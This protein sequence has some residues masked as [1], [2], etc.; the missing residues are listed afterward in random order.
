MSISAVFDRSQVTHE[1][2]KFDLIDRTKFDLSEVTLKESE[3]ALMEKAFLSETTSLTDGALIMPNAIYAKDSIN[4]WR[5]KTHGLPYHIKQKL[6][7]K[8]KATLNRAPTENDL[9]KYHKYANGDLR[10]AVELFH[11][12]I[13][14]KQLWL[15]DGKTIESKAKLIAN[16]T[17]AFVT[18]IQTDGYRGRKWG[19]KVS[20]Y[21]TIKKV[22]EPDLAE[23]G[24]EPLFKLTKKSK[25]KD[26]YSALIRY[27]S[28][29]YLIGKFEKQAD[30]LREYIEILFGNVRDYSTPYASRKC[31]NEFKASRIQQK[32][33]INDMVIQDIDD[34][35]NVVPLAA[36]IASSVS[37]PVIRRNELMT[38]IR[39]FENIAEESGFV[40][41]FITL[42]APSAYHANSR[43]FNGNKPNKTQKYLTN[44]WAKVRAKLAR[45]NIK[46]FGVRVTEPHA[47][48]TPH[49]HMILFFQADD[50]QAVETS[51]FKYFTQ[52]HWQELTNDKTDECDLLTIKSFYKNRKLGDVDL[53][54][55]TKA[56]DRP[57][58]RV[59]FVDIDK[60]FGS[61]TG[62]IAKY[63]A[64]NIDAAH[65]TDKETGKPLIDDETGKPINDET[66]I[67]VLAWTSRWRIRQ[68]QFL[69]G[70]PVTTYREC[71]K[72]MNDYSIEDSV[73]KDLTGSTDEFDE[74]NFI[75]NFQEVLNA[76]DTGNFAKYVQLTGGA[77][78][79][80]NG[81]IKTLLE[82]IENST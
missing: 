39:G 56:Y 67:G 44:T 36:A 64:K 13:N 80:R 58:R 47:D 78:Q 11:K 46:Y 14:Q 12:Y 2:P 43:K 52:Q 53:K 72:F 61:A 74:S 10:Q 19:G 33:W 34:P 50:K 4:F 54:E 37:N 60:N 82:E 31:Q 55:I 22:V 75:D 41:S 38:R 49:W 66:V 27:M 42:T 69:G 23:L 6:F 40:G 29:E 77:F 17:N 48:A 15:L 28:D 63:V 7:A 32:D 35:E 18:D 30:Q 16:S 20:A 71:R 3:I 62:Y 70:A 24:L 65:C 81:S 45:E 5:E 21:I 73:L 26:Y 79:G 8:Y 68:F 76:A 51:I 57:E 9:T 1:L 25:L 59:K